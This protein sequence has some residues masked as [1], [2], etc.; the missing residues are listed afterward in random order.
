MNET[1]KVIMYKKKKNSSKLTMLKFKVIVN[2]KIKRNLLV[3]MNHQRQNIKSPTL[4][5]IVLNK[6]KTIK[7]FKNNKIIK[8]IN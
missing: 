5:K 1:Y 7:V 3:Q 8:K 4:M 6:S 2:N